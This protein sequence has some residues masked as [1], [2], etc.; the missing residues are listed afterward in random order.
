MLGSVLEWHWP[1]VFF[2]HWL[3]SIFRL[4]FL[5]GWVL[6]N[7]CFASYISSKK[8]PFINKDCYVML[9]NYFMIVG[10]TPSNSRRVQP[11]MKCWWLQCCL[12]YIDDM[13]NEQM[14][15]FMWPPITGQIHVAIPSRYIM[16]SIIN[17]LVLDRV[18][19]L[20]ILVWTGYQ[21]R[22]QKMPMFD[23]QTLHSEQELV[24]I[25]CDSKEKRF[26]Y[27]ICVFRHFRQDRSKIITP[28]LAQD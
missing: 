22:R 11:W 8:Y 4:G 3:C 6:Y 9:I 2:L 21:A 19:L 10:L 27:Q 1:F 15:S 18:L 23:I 25:C 7:V 28:Y 26:P 13:W 5:A 12:S 24:S 20:N 14:D 16:K 17:S